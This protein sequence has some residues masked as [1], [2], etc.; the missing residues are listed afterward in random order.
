MISKISLRTNIISKMFLRARM[1]SKMS[2]RARMISKMF[3]RA[4]MILNMSLRARMI[5][6]CPWGL[7]WYF[8]SIVL[9]ILH[10]NLL[11]SPLRDI[12]GSNTFNKSTVRWNLMHKYLVIHL[13]PFFSPRFSSFNFFILILELIITN[14]SFRPFY[15]FVTLYTPQ[16][17]FSKLKILSK[18]SFFQLSLVAFLCII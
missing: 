17:H 15:T 6:K 1:I 4:I 11:F 12:L 3:L 10:Y 16:P 7:K 5:S 8:F 13:P 2:I 18:P 9:T 14:S